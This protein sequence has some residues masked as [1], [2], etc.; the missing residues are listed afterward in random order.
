MPTFSKRGVLSHPNG[1]YLREGGRFD[2]KPYH[3]EKGQFKRLRTEIE[4]EGGIERMYE[5]YQTW[6]AYDSI[7]VFFDPSGRTDRSGIS[8]AT[9]LRLDKERIPV[10]TA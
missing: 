2:G 3:V 7:P 8:Y 1:N 6:Y 10:K 4:Q 9:N 5:N